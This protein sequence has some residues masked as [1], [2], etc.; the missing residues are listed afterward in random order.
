MLRRTMPTVSLVA[1]RFVRAVETDGSYDAEV[2]EEVLPFI[3]A[4]VANLIRA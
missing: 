2:A 1:T 3:D 4:A